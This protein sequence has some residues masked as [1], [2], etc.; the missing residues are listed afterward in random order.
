MA[1][2]TKD[3]GP[4]VEAAPV[5]AVDQLDL[6]TLRK[7]APR[8]AAILEQ[9]PEIQDLF[10]RAYE[11]NWQGANGRALFDQELENLRFWKENAAPAREYIIRAMNPDDPDFQRLLQDSQEYVRKV[12]RETGRAIAEE[13]VVRLS[14]ESL[15]RG[16]GDPGRKDQLVRRLMGTLDGE[17]DNRAFGEVTGGG[18]YGEYL[19]KLRSTADA[20]GVDFGSGWYES[21]AASM[22]SNLTDETFWMSK[23]R[24]QAASKFPVFKDQIMAGVNMWDIAS[25]YINMM[26]KEWEVAPTSITFNDPTLL[27]ALSGFTENGQPRAMDLGAF[28][29]KLRQ[30]P[31]WLETSSA[32]NEITSVAGKMMEMFGVTG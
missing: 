8:V 2:K 23:I 19:S 29:L 30:D 22:A 10:R 12:A 7:I 20:N 15:M 31:R 6:P 21:A 3:T 16:W 28:R 11:G 25:P 27:S 4:T 5:F 17:P 1:S 24:E 13:D 9:D 26:A 18:K 14:E 32:Q